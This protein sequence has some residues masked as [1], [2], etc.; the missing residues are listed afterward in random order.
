MTCMGDWEIWSVS[1]RLLDNLGE[2]ALSVNRLLMSVKIKQGERARIA[3]WDFSLS[4][5]L[6]AIS[7][8]L[9]FPLGYNTGSC[10]Q[11][12]LAGIWIEKMSTPPLGCFDIRPFF[13]K[14]VEAEI[15]QNFKNSSGWE[16]IK[17]VLILLICISSDR[18]KIKV[19]KMLIN[20]NTWSNVLYNTG[21]LTTWHTS[22]FVIIDS[23]YL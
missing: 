7:T 5:P 22:Q 1:R 23:S 12:K 19:T 2:L 3:G 14:N 18:H 13:C 11:A 17:N 21:F 16:L 9:F 8:S 10:L 20:P 15:N 4:R 6:S